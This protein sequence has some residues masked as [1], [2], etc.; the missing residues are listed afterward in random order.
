MTAIPAGVGRPHFGL[1]FDRTVERGRRH[2]LPRAVF[3]L[4]L[5]LELAV[6]SVD[7]RALYRALAPKIAGT[8]RAVSGLLGLFADYRVPATWA[9]VGQLMRDTT[10][11]DID[12]ADW[13]GQEI[14]AEYLRAPELI[15]EI[16]A[17]PITQDIG[18]HSYR[19][20]N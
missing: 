14:P 17:C 8:R 11:L 18:L 3:V 6:A 12:V 20:I 9:I 1:P 13:V 10:E 15:D 4:S 16:G 2:P 5:D 7:Q 19:H